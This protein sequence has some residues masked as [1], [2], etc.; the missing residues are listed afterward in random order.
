MLLVLPFFLVVASIFKKSFEGV[1]LK[2]IADDPIGEAVVAL[3][4]KVVSISFD[5]RTATAEDL[6]KYEKSNSGGYEDQ[7]V[8]TEQKDG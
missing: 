1:L 6:D 2:V 8:Q 4:V 3:D 7:L 5:T